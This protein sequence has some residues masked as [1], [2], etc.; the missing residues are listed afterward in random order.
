MIGCWSNDLEINKF[1][2]S[3]TIDGYFKLEKTI[4]RKINKDMRNLEGSDFSNLFMNTVKIY[5]TFLLPRNFPGRNIYML[6]FDELYYF[7][8][9]LKKR[10][11]MKKIKNKFKIYKDCILY[12]FAGNPPNNFKKLL[13]ALEKIK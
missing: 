12:Q 10:R 5:Y 1:I 11:R 3:P 6:C 13:A 4:R 9:S 7:K 8:K 2:K